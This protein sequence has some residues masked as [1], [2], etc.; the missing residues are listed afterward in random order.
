[1]PK[2]RL[3]H[4]IKIEKLGRLRVWQMRSEPF[5]GKS[6]GVR[7]Q[8]KAY[9][10][11]FRMRTQDFNQGVN[12]RVGGPNFKTQPEARAWERGYGDAAAQEK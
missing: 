11:G 9:E 1:M 3:T 10:Q 4:V 12:D 5:S 6:R 2:G 8:R 7:A